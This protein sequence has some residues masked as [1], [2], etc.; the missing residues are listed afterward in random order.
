MHEVLRSYD[1]FWFV[2]GFLSLDPVSTMLMRLVCKEWNTFV[3]DPCPEAL[4]SFGC[5]E[6]ADVTGCTRLVRA[7]MRGGMGK[8]VASAMYLWPEYLATRIAST[9][10]LVD[11]F[12]R[13]DVMPVA[14]HLLQLGARPSSLVLSTLFCRR[15]YDIASSIMM[16]MLANNVCVTARPPSKISDGGFNTSHVRELGIMCACDRICRSSMLVNVARKR[17]VY[18]DKIVKTVV[19]TLGLEPEDLFIALCRTDMLGGFSHFGCLD[20]M[21]AVFG[22]KDNWAPQIMTQ[23]KK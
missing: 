17:A 3:L 9:L 19:D 23:L 4:R 7:M 13:R 2:L 12:A 1:L 18:G 21:E 8:S 5:A 22:P 11:Y 15:Q 10:M 16:F 20:C 14:V 6:P